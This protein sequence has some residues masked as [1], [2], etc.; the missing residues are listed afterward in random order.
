VMTKSG[1]I[2][3]ADKCLCALELDG[4]AL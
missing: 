1:S 3:K 2:L 4:S